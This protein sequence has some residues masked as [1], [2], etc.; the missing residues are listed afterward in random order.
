MMK[1]LLPLGCAFLI[2]ILEGIALYVGINGKCLALSFA[3]IGGLGG[4]GLREVIQIV[5]K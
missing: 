1:I 4:Y 5:K 2:A 3:L